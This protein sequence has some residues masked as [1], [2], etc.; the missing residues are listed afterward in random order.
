MPVPT[1]ETYD[2]QE[3]QARSLPDNNQTR[4]SNPQNS[5]ST[6]G[7]SYSAG[8]G[9]HAQTEQALSQAEA[10]RLYVERMEDEYAKRDGGA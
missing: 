1:A 10:D 5:N 6:A 9:T 7:T 2:R 4:G 8:T 3:A